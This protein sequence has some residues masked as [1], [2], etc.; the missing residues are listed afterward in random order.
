MYDSQLTFM[1]LAILTQY[2]LVF[3]MKYT[4]HHSIWTKKNIYYWLKFNS[5]GKI[6]KNTNKKSFSFSCNIEI[7]NMLMNEW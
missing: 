2:V 4:Q 3:S 6:K 5:W 7:S 1:F